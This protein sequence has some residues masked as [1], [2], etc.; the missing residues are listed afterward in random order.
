MQISVT[1][2]D[3]MAMKSCGS[4]SHGVTVI[5]LLGIVQWD[6]EGVWIGG[7]LEGKALLFMAE[8]QRGVR[9]PL[10]Q[11]DLWIAA[12]IQIDLWLRGLLN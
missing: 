3:S 1:E 12:V 8:C 4:D 6:W 5:L 11:I 10:I 9:N 2:H 7:S